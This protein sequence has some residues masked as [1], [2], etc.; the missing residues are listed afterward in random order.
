MASP[1]FQ[2]NRRRHRPTFPASDPVSLSAQPLAAKDLGWAAQWTDWLL[3]AVAK[4][5]GFFLSIA[6][7]FFAYCIKIMGNVTDEAGAGYGAIVAATLHELFGVTVNPA[8]VNTRA[9]GPERAAVAASLGQ[10]IIGTMFSS[11]PVQASGGVPPSDAAANNFLRVVMNM[12]LNGW[13]ES[14]F[15][16]AATYHLLE[17][18]GDL[19]DGIS[20]TLGLGRMSRQVFA[21]PLKVLV[22][23]PYQALLDQKYRPKHVDVG[24]AMRAF[25]R[26]DT[27]RAGL[28]TILG[29]QGYTEQEIDWLILDHAKYL[30]NEDVDYLVARGAW[31]G[32]Q[33]QQYLQHQGWDASSASTV[34]KVLE[35]KR[36]QKYRTELVQ[37]AVDGYVHG[38]VNDAQLSSYLDSAGIPDSEKL[39]VADVAG[40]KRNLHVTH[41]SRGDIEHG[42][43]DGVLNFNDLKA[44]AERNNMPLSEEVFLELTVQVDE[45]KA[46]GA[47]AAKAAAAKTRADAQAAKTAAAT[48][49]ANAAKAQAA[50]KGITVAEAEAL[51]RAGNW[52]FAQLEGFLTIEGLWA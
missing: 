42:I 11:A 7:K 1:K 32:A 48:A 4:I 22:H 26:G 9:S 46:A 41:L 6:L 5:A 8:S 37:N 33:A 15:A 30:P 44:W 2:W 13:L 14:W 12:Q 3:Q 51:V 45:N 39:W 38:E 29:N 18:Y 34:L 20:H 47:A 35:D 50:D 28:S 24:T 19:K 43:K 31:T 10:A 27:D 25:H 36:L 49:K 17:K 52:T 16:D 40:N 23:D 21:P